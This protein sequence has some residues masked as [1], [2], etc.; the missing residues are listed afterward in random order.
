MVKAHRISHKKF[1]QYKSFRALS[2]QPNTQLKYYEGQGAPQ[3]VLTLVKQSPNKISTVCKDFA[4]EDYHLEEPPSEV[5]CDH[6]DKDGIQMTRRQ[7]EEF[8][9]LGA[10]S[11]QGRSE[12]GTPQMPP[13]QPRR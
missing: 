5:K 13:T 3:N 1:G 10:G 4:R 2:T 12:S 7:K 6:V 8:P 11:L 9:P